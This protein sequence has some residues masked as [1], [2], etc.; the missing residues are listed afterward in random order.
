[1]AGLRRFV[2]WR[3]FLLLESPSWK[4]DAELLPVVPMS[5]NWGLAYRHEPSVAFVASFVPGPPGFHT[6]L[7]CIYSISLVHHR[8]RGI[9]IVIAM[10]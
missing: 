9:T 7:A 6:V 4:R 8:A 3:G 1:M 5:L 2:A 10:Q